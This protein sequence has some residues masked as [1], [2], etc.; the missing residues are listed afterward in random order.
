MRPVLRKSR[1]RSSTKIRKIRPAASL[2]RPRRR[3]DDAFLRRR[4]WRLRD[5][6]DAPAVRQREGDQLLLDAVFEN[7]E[8]VFLEV[9]DELPAAVAHDRVGGNQLDAGADHLFGRR[10]ARSWRCAGGFWAPR[11]VPITS[12]PAS[13]HGQINRGRVFTCMLRLYRGLPSGLSLARPLAVARTDGVGPPSSPEADTSLGNSGSL[14]GESSESLPSAW[15]PAGSAVRGPFPRR[16]RRLRCPTTS[17]RDA[18]TDS[19]CSRPWVTSSSVTQESGFRRS[20]CA[21]S[22][23]WRCGSAVRSEIRTRISA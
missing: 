15:P 17:R 4:R 8:L 22:S 14:P 9:R 1:C 5:V 19:Y 2:R 7:L 21:F 20:A 23:S 16:R 10:R 13:A 3:Q 12:A 6:V 11:G 18:S